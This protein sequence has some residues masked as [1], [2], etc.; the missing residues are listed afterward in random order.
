MRRIKQFFC[1]HDNIKDISNEHDLKLGLHY[2]RCYRCKKIFNQ[3]LVIPK[4]GEH[5]G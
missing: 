3:W 5:N 1:S 4:E 2:Y